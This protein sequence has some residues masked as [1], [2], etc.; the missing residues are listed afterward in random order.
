MKLSIVSTLYKSAP[1]ID[2]FYTRVS[3]AA[4]NISGNDYE[5]IFV[6]DGSPD[7]CLELAIN[8]MESDNKIVVVNLSRN[9]GHHAAIVA[10]LEQAKGDR[11]FLIDSDL[12]EQPEWLQIF[13]DKME[14]TGADVIYGIQETRIGSA[15][16]RI[17]GSLFWKS[18]NLM[19]QI[20]IPHNPMTCRLMS[21]DYVNALISVGD[22]VL[23]LAGVFAWTGFRQ[24]G[25][26]LV[27]TPRT[28]GGRSTYSLSRKLLQVVDS[29]SSFN[30]APLMLVF[31]AGIIIWSVSIFFGLYLLLQKIID[32]EMVL[33]GFTSMMLSIWFLSGSI[34]VCLGV[35]GLYVS[36]IFQE[37]KRRPLYITK[38]VL[39]KK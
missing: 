37:V 18:I 20:R 10:G 15:P 28:T 33:S 21:R 9:F 4:A 36:K 12:E 23:Y 17:F 3:S 27:K 34:I 6:N 14:E 35:I 22:R 31:F 2:E 26:P 11:V 7:N 25:I 30:I 19:S 16:S 39:S 29:F 8:K 32:P 24:V 1:Y 38:E 5:V 13:H